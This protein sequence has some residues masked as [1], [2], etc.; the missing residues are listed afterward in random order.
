MSV[1]Y[2]LV[3][4]LF[5][6]PLGRYTLQSFSKDLSAGPSLRPSNDY[7]LY[8][9]KTRLLFRTHSSSPPSSRSSSP[10]SHFPPPSSRAIPSRDHCR[11]CVEY[12]KPLS[13]CT[14][15]SS[16]TLVPRTEAILSY[17]DS[18]LST[19]LKSKFPVL[20]PGVSCTTGVGDGP[21]RDQGSGYRCPPDHVGV[22]TDS[23]NPVH[24]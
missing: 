7:P 10:S 9:H 1:L 21:G 13:L 14:R 16:E 24:S 4:I 15:P 3:G 12:R 8:R 17:P 19:S 5:L 6:H 20:R 23:S 11:L 22:R 18:H 2:F